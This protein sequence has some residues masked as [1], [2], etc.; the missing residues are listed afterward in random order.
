MS[1]RLFAILFFACAHKYMTETFVTQ[2]NLRTFMHRKH[3]WEQ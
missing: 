2:A 3:K 1:L